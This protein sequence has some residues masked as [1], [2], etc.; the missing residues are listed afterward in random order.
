MVS[1][2]RLSPETGAAIAGL[3]ALRSLS[4]D[5]ALIEPEVVAATAGLP[6][7]TALSLSGVPD[8]AAMA[9]L[10]ALSQ[11]RHLSLAASTHIYVVAELP[12]PAA[13]PAL[14]SF[15]AGRPRGVARL[16]ASRRQVEWHRRAAVRCGPACDALL[17]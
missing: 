13:F 12:A 1:E 8:G 7:L 15:Q 6:H 9:Q 2:G 10:T 5:A 4:I 14:V 11:L 3:T 16:Q 17:L